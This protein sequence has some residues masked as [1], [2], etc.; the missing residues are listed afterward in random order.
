MQVRSLLNS[1][2]RFDSSLKMTSSLKNLPSP[3]KK[4]A[5]PLVEE[6]KKCAGQEEKKKERRRRSV[7]S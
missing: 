6:V 1:A 5:K 7:S 2:S 4:E 3:R